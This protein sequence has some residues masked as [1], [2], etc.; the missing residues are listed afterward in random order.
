MHKSGHLVLSCYEA[1]FVLYFVCIFISD[2]YFMA[3][4][5]MHLIILGRGGVGLKMF[6]FE[7]FF[8]WYSLWVCCFLGLFWWIHSDITRHIH[9]H[10]VH[11]YTY[12]YTYT[13]LF[14]NNAIWKKI[15]EIYITFAFSPKS[16]SFSMFMNE[17]C[18]KPHEYGC[19]LQHQW[20]HI[21]IT[22]VQNL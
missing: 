7:S 21:C 6:N 4:L 2:A 13:H 22:F 18:Y 19:Q 14:W 1:G 3:S 8:L 10:I 11:N 15:H 5:L 12:T 16:V 17:L 20:P 9:I